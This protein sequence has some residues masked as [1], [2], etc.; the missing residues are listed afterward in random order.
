[1]FIDID[2]RRHET[3]VFTPEAY[4]FPDS[5][6]VLLHEGLGCV[7]LWKNFPQALADAT[8]MDVVAYS[9]AGYGDS[10]PVKVPRPLSYMHEEA[11]VWLPKILASLDYKK[12]ML[13][14]HSDGGS[15]ALIHAG[16][17]ADPRISGVITLAA[18]V[19]NEPVCVASIEQAKEVYEQ[20]G[21]RDSLAR[22]HGDNVDVAF[23][24]WNQAWL[25]PDF[26]AW[27]IEEYLPGIRVPLMAVQGENDEY[28]TTDQINAICRQAG[29]ACEPVLLPNC[30]HAIHRDA[31]AELIGAIS[32]FI[33]KYQT[34]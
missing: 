8:G 29:G 27:N 17:C 12:L 30:R 16:S 13:V 31:P 11:E 33:S 3:R 28:G 26:M 21:L 10:S 5:A 6:F 2:G 20:G 34:V 24:G 19:F 7:A 23:W 9:R 22:Y 1:M 18:H 14:G 4:L 25:H 32:G 15:I